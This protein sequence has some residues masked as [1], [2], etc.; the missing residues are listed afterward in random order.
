MTIVRLT[1]L[2]T[3]GTKA[4]L[5]A[6]IDN[7]SRYVLDWKVSADISAVN[8]RDLLLS[9]LAKAK[10]KILGDVGKPEV[11][12]DGGPEN[13]NADVAG[14]GALGLFTLTLAQIDVTF[15]NSLIDVHRIMGTKM[16]RPITRGGKSQQGR[17]ACSQYSWLLPDLPVLT[18][19]FT[20][21]NLSRECALPSLQPMIEG[22]DGRQ[23]Q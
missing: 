18:T 2:L 20:N 16:R 1:R 13:D 3:G 9:A 23:L 19:Q 14:L 8:T 6:F 5:Q 11:Y 10:M 4:Y 17:E 22:N 21:A 12:S 15:S 7:Y